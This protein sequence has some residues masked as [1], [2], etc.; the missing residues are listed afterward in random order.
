MSFDRVDLGFGVYYLT[1]FAN[2]NMESA[3]VPIIKVYPKFH[4]TRF[5]EAFVIWKEGPQVL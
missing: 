4:G 5:Y 2:V 1:N 3:T